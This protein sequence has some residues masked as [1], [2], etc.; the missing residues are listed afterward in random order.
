MAR[1]EVIDERDQK[2]TR[3]SNSSPE[4][5]RNTDY[6]DTTNPSRAYS[7]PASLNEV[8][9]VSGRPTHSSSLIFHI[10]RAMEGGGN[11]TGR[12]LKARQDAFLSS[13]AS[14]K[15]I[16]MVQMHMPAMQ[17]DLAHNYAGSDTSVLNDLAESVLKG[18]GAGGDV[19]DKFGVGAGVMKERSLDRMMQH[20]LNSKNVVMETGKI[21]K[22]RGGLLYNG[23]GLR[24]HTFRYTLRPRSI[25]E[26][27]AVGEIIHTFRLFSSGSRSGFDIVDDLTEGSSFGI[28]SAPP[29]WFVEERA[30]DNALRHI[31]KFYFGP[32][33]I[34]N[35]KVNKTP[36]QIYQTIA[37]TAG[38][39]VEVELEITMQEMIPAYA[40]FWKKT[41]GLRNSLS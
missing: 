19:W 30:H 13:P 20:G 34:T 11:L 33:S 29:I 37:N 12:S 3:A 6:E 23:T 38:D 22:Q 40:D 17:E 28:V 41:R 25:A 15:T 21:T 18:M 16:G 5:S 14:M 36:E 4:K 9:P 24:S 8:D 31:D 27:K 10:C 1:V 39:P 35:V 32:A 26:L 2:T 7:F